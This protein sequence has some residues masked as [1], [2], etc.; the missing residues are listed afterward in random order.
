MTTYELSARSKKAAALVAVLRGAGVSARVARMSYRACEWERVADL[1]HVKPPSAATIALVIELLDNSEDCI[2]LVASGSHT[3]THGDESGHLSPARHMAMGTSE[4]S[5][6][7]ELIAGGLDD[8]FPDERVWP[9]GQEWDVEAMQ[10]VPA[11][12]EEVDETT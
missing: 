6:I 2:P 3:T 9:E 10:P 12:Q 11:Q 4:N 1:A 8:I 7:D 5:R